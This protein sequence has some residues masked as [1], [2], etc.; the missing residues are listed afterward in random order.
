MFLPVLKREDEPPR[1][2]GRVEQPLRLED[3]SRLELRVTRAFLYFA[4]IQVTKIIWSSSGK[5][6]SIFLHASCFDTA[7]TRREV[8]V[9][10]KYDDSRIARTHVLIIRVL[11]VLG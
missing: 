3:A 6:R 7:T 9:M 11:E 2:G 10:S 8:L 5:N 1:S 4:F